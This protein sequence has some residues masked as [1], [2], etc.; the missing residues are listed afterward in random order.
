MALGL[1][2]VLT[3]V[4]HDT[5]MI[6]LLA[7]G[8]AR[9]ESSDNP[10]PIRKFDPAARMKGYRYLGRE[11]D[12]IRGEVERIDALRAAVVG[13]ESSEPLFAGLRWDV[14]GLLGFYT[15]GRPQAWSFGLALG[16]RHSQYDLW[17]PNP[18]DDAQAFRGRTFLVVSGGDVRAPLA[19][20]FE[21]VDVP[22]E[23]IY[24]EHGRALARW[25]VHVC[26]GFK[27]FDPARRPG[28]AAEH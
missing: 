19:T 25:Y 12:V 10:T 23:I 21:S 6:T 17:H 7:A 14:P 11:L 27:G 16:D 2:V 5:R 20:A 3:F 22:Q 13:A 18:V 28:T 8:Y 9:P 15:D 24:R 4:A 1:G 26:R